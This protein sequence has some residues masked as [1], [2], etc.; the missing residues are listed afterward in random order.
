MDNDLGQVVEVGLRL[1]AVLVV[2]A[3]AIK[4]GKTELLTD[5]NAAVEKFV[6]GLSEPEK[7]E[8]KKDMN[9]MMDQKADQFVD[10]LSKTLK[11]EE[12]DKVIADLGGVTQSP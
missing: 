3:L 6:A 9:A 10:E 5:V 1:Q 4:L 2:L 12:V 11:P 8:L 7:E